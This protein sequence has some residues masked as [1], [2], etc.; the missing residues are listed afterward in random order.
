MSTALYGIIIA[1]V[2]AAELAAIWLILFGGA[3]AGRRRFSAERRGQ[4]DG[5]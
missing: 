5:Q 1:G 4:R 3:R 2:G